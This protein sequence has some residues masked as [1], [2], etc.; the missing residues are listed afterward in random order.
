MGTILLVMA[1]AT[2]EVGMFCTGYTVKFVR[3]EQ[4]NLRHPG[5]KKHP[6][7][8]FRGCFFLLSFLWPAGVGGWGAGGAGAAGRSRAGGGG[9]KPQS[10]R[11][12]GLRSNVQVEATYCIDMTEIRF[13]TICH[14]EI[15]LFHLILIVPHYYMCVEVEQTVTSIV[16]PSSCN[17]ARYLTSLSTGI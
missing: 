16:N 4:K 15:E 1:M 11:T 9:S 14:I 10:S 7:V 3:R 8:D 5:T 6:N 17:A 2:A 13:D 12:S